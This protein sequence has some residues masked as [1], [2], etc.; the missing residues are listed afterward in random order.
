[1]V[2]LN[3]SSFC[4]KHTCVLIYESAQVS[5]GLPVCVPQSFQLQYLSVEMHTHAD[6]LVNSDLC[7]ASRGPSQQS[8]GGVQRHIM[9][10]L[11]HTQ[12][13]VSSAWRSLH[14]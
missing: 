8:S 12:C 10:G 9:S 11:Q 3:S 7:S 13:V 6:D 4:C 1:M 14:F 2:C 5:K